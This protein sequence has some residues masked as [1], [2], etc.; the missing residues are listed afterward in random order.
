MFKMAFKWGRMLSLQLSKMK[1]KKHAGKS[2]NASGIVD[3]ISPYIM[4][5]G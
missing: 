3:T 5:V 1:L 4:D 2:A